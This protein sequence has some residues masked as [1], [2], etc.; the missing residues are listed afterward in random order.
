MNF[1]PL[2]TFPRNW[3]FTVKKATLKH[4]KALVVLY[5]DTQLCVLNHI[6]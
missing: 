1:N 3:I 2:L 5:T 4:D 6:Q